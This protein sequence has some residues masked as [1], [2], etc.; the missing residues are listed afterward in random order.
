MTSSMTLV[1]YLLA[2]AYALRLAWP[3]E[4]YGADPRYRVVDG[5]RIC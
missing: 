2:A 4:T 5:M 1:P 3:A